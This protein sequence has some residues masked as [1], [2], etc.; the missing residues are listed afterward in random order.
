MPLFRVTKEI[1]F[2]V[3]AKDADAALESVKG[4]YL[5]EWFL[6]ETVSREAMWT[7]EDKPIIA[8]HRELLE[9]C[10]DAARD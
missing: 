6:H 7:V 8:A 4:V 1:Q 9:R 3:D 2:Y 10:N 5:D